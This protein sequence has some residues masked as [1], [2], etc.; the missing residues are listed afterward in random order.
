MV[1]I[2][3][4][5]VSSLIF[6]LQILP[7]PVHLSEFSFWFFPGFFVNFIIVNFI[8][9]NLRQF[10]HCCHRTTQRKRWWMLI[11]IYIYRFWTLKQDSILLTD[12][13]PHPFSPKS[14]QHFFRCSNWWKRMDYL[15]AI[16]VVYMAWYFLHTLQKILRAGA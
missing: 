15:Q 11:Y 12:I 2:L 1:T 6:P 5:L 7:S 14:D 13:H 16:K 4:S 9:G 3:P 10:Y 8:I